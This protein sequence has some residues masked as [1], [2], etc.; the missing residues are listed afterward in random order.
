MVWHLKWAGVFLFVINTFLGFSALAQTPARPKFKKQTIELNYKK[1]KKQITVEVAQSPAELEH[2][3]M[4]KERLGPNE[5]ML[6]IFK[7]LNIREFWMKNTWINLD[8]GYFD[9]NK[10]LTEVLQME[11]IKTMLHEAVPTYPS[12]LPAQYALEMNQGWFKKN[13]FEAGTTFKLILRPS[14]AKK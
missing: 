8:I 12:K 1:I 7:D 10:K 14:S 6:F 3:L 5:G 11:A 9:N 4:Y 2:G 13:G